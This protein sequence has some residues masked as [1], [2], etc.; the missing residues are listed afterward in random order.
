MRLGQDLV[1]QKLALGS[2]VSDGLIGDWGL[3]NGDWH[4]WLGLRWRSG[5]WEIDETDE[6]DEKGPVRC[7]A[8]LSWAKL[9]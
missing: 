3:A 9:G 6:D 7:R 1:G 4:G 8:G 2:M 5:P